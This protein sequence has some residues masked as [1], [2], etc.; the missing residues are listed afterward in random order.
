MNGFLA[1][2]L[3]AVTLML[4][5]SVSAGVTLQGDTGDIKPSDLTVLKGIL[6]PAGVVAAVV[7]SAER[8][9][10][11]QDE[12]MYDYAKTKGLEQAKKT[13]CPAGDEVLSKF[14]LVESK[15]V[16]VANMESELVRQLPRARDLGCLNHIKND[17][18]YAIDIG[19]DTLNPQSAKDALGSTMDQ[20]MRA[21]TIAR[22][23]HPNS[24][25]PDLK[26]FHFEF[27]K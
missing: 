20:A 18:V 6:D 9:P 27:K 26:A 2:I 19:L 8:S 25:P 22:G 1:G 17:R 23:L 4:A 3:A 13:Y 16:V 21:G 14:S 5:Q 24:T 15:E 11:G 12:A 10:H 7:S